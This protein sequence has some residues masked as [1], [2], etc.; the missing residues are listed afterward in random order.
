[1][2]F[3]EKSG[4][5]RVNWYEMW[6]RSHLPAAGSADVRL[7]DV[8]SQWAC[9]ALWGPNARAL[10]SGCTTADLSDA[11]AGRW[12]HSPQRATAGRAV[13]A[14]RTAGSHASPPLPR[15]RYQRSLLRPSSAVTVVAPLT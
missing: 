11:A 14:S 3:G 1:V 2:V 8:T 13:G 4:W 12:I 10:L 6:I 7:A 15:T 5:E 9:F